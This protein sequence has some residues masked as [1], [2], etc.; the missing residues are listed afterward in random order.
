MGTLNEVVPDIG[1][2]GHVVKAKAKPS[3]DWLLAA[4]WNG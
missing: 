3:S 4:V 1:K 2:C